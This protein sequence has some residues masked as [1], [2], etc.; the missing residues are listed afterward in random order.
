M[1]KEYLKLLVPISLNIIISV[2]FYLL[3]KRTKFSKLNYPLRQIIIGVVFGALSAFSSDYGAVLNTIVIN[4]RDAAPI[5]AA[6]L[7]GGPAGIISG[8]IGGL[9]RW[10]SVYW[11]A[12]MYTRLACSLSTI[13]VS[14]IATV[15]KRFM[16]DNKKPTVSYAISIA[17]VCEVIHMMMIFVTNMND[18]MKAFAIINQCTLPMVIGNVLAVGISVFAVTLLSNNKIKVDKE[19]RQISQTFQRWLLI[20]V[21]ISFVFTTAFSFRLQ[22]GM[23][24]KQTESTITLALSDVYNDIKDA[25]DKNII[26]VAYNAKVQYESAKEK[27]KETLVS[28]SKKNNIAEINIIDKNGYIV[29]STEDSFVG[30]DMSSGEQSEEFLVLLN[31]EEEFVQEFQPISIDQTN[32]R[33]Y[34]GVLLSDG[35]FIQIGY[36]PQGFKNDIHNLLTTAIQN[37]HLGQ[38]GFLAICD[39]E[40][41]VLVNSKNLRSKN[42]ENMGIQL[43]L[44]TMEENKVYTASVNNTEYYYSYSTNEG[45]IIIGAIPVSEAIFIRNATTIINSFMM[46]LIFAT[47]FLLVYF[48][49]K[50]V[51]INNLKKINESLS[52]ISSGNLD[53]VVD[54]RSNKEFSSLSD[55]INSTVQTLKNYIKEASARLDKELEYAQTIQQAA[56]PSE[57]SLPENN[58]FN[59]TAQMIAAKEVGGDFYDYYMLNEN[60]VAFLVADVSGKG[61]PAAMFMMRAKTVLKSLAEQNLSVDKIFTIANNTLCDNNESDMFVT[62]WMGILDLS[63]GK[64]QFANAGHTSPLIMRAGKDYEYLKTRPGFI[65]AGMEGIKYQLN[66][67]D[68]NYGDRILL[69]TDGV[70]EASNQNSELYGEKR[71]LDFMNEHKDSVFDYTLDG[72]KT[73]IDA[74]AR[75][76]PQSDDI[77]MLLFSYVEKIGGVTMIEKTFPADTS[78]LKDIVCFTEEELK[79]L[80]CP[81][82]VIMPTSLAVEEV[83]TN[84]ANYAY[85]EKSG[86]VKYI[87]RFNHSTRSASFRFIDNGIK[88]NPL[89]KPDPDVTL[90]AEKRKVGGLGIFLTKKV[91]DDLTYRY[92]KGSNILTLY[93]KL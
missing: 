8:C 49:I 4:V 7:F 60:T 50:T 62:A 40:F 78:A 17:V 24:S 5:N 44:D 37:R 38:T 66:E 81:K 21:A 28:I 80:D 82:K 72:L 35:G 43:D 16:F 54:V 30:Y 29:L 52:A 45:F 58:N 88:F 63:T 39:D 71:L 68:L 67:I 89:E 26:S 14:I 20:C 55:D 90:S 19:Q 23:S 22:T 65:M 93:K 3:E 34:G 6:L 73:S 15:L 56:L 75:G 76:A 77:T 64:L 41:N 59:I 33:K 91:M 27:N 86:D 1:E 36:D 70:T 9:Y 32:Y 84:I 61:I 48:L 53:V 25:S 87:F 47:L 69:Y 51:I 46:V 10:F 11:G 85:G 13:L 2:L 42:L 83:F 12:G 92:E 18:S 57:S 31:G 74:F 79:K